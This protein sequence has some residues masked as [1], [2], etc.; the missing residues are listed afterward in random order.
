MSMSAKEDFI[1]G[2]VLLFGIFLYGILPFLILKA[3]LKG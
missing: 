3:L 2:L 1:D